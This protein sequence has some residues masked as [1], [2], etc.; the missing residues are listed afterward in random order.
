MGHLQKKLNSQTAWRLLILTVFVILT[1][2]LFQRPINH[3][4]GWYLYASG[5]ILDGAKIYRDLIDIN[6]P[7]IFWLNIPPVWLARLLNCSAVPLF[8][9]FSFSSSF[10]R[11]PSP[12]TYLRRFFCIC[13]DP[14]NIVFWWFLFFYLYRMKCP[15]IVSDNANTNGLL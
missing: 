2:L 13:H 7:L 15:G 14:L 3:D 5:A 1:S 11:L 10:C 8:N 4:A 12:R 9:F 6:P